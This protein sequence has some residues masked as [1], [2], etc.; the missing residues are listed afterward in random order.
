VVSV[1]LAGVAA[2]L[3]QSSGRVAAVAA[4]RLEQGAA[5]V[6][7]ASQGLDERIE[8]VRRAAG[9]K[10][11]SVVFH[12]LHTGRRFAH[13]ASEWYHAASTIKVPVMVAVFEAVENGALSLDT[14]VPVRNSYR[15]MVDGSPFSIP[16]EDGANGAV[17]DWVG[18]TRS[19]SDM[20]RAMITTSS[21]LATNELIAAV[22]F[23]VTRGTIAGLGIAGIDFQRPLCDDKAF[24][25]G[26]NNRVTAGGLDELF[27]RLAL[28]VVVSPDASRKMLAI[29][30]EQQHNPGIPAGLPASLNAR[31][32]HKTGYIST[33]AHDS[34]LVCLPHRRPY[35][36]TVLTE[37][38]KGTDDDEAERM[39]CI[40]RITR[41]VHDALVSP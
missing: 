34:G 15:S 18:K 19:I 33:V 26:L 17:H 25:A 21:N 2:L 31:I 27:T 3:S 11:A 35:A 7:R 1:W 16:R 36:L 23:P 29:C 24:D 8:E 32:A 5:A 39:K 20:L 22:G 9:A 40:A 28:G 41:A 10:R 12:D 6:S 4:V 37:W 13:G 38:P 14:A 30:F